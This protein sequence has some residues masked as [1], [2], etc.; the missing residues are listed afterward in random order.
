[1][2]TTLI[3]DA[4]SA[5]AFGGSGW[6]LELDAITGNRFDSAT[7][8]TSGDNA[9]SNDDYLL[10]TGYG[11]AKLNT[12]ARRIAAV[13]AAPGFMGNKNGKAALEDKFI[14]TSDGSVVR[15]RE[16]SGKGGEGR[17][18]WRELK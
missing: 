16:T 15:V 17:V 3:P 2:F 9:L 12:S 1:V 14:N 6:V 10:F 13:P 4:T 11:S 8:D 18:M 7:F 5:C